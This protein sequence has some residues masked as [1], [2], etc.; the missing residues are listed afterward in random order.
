AGRTRAARHPHRQEHRPHGLAWRDDGLRPRDRSPAPARQAWRTRFRGNALT[1]AF[2]ERLT[3]RDPP[4]PGPRY[5]TC[6]LLVLRQPSIYNEIGAC[7]AAAF[8]RAEE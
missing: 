8:I 5:Q 4:R 3:R 2:H 1:R 6:A 7:A